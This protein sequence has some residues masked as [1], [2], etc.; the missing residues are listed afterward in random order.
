[1]P[2]P[3]GEVPD[4]GSDVERH[5]SEPARP[6]HA[7][8][9]GASGGQLARSEMDDRVERHDRPQLTVPGRQREQVAQAEFG[10]RML[11]AG[12]GDHAVGQI[13]AD[14]GRAV[15]GQPARDVARAAAEVGHR[16]TV[17]GL[18][19]EGAEQGP[20][21]WLVREFVAETVGVSAGHGVIAAAGHLVPPGYFHA[22]L[23]VTVRDADKDA[24]RGADKDAVRGA[25]KDAVRGAD[26]DA[27]RG[28]DK[29]AVRGADKD[30]GRKRL[31][32]AG[33]SPGSG[34]REGREGWAR[35]ATSLGFG[36]ATCIVALPHG[37]R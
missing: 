11:P 21:E 12:H 32:R 37:S 27:V 18:L 15:P 5:Q 16:R 14:H 17:P 29:D 19:D 36:G 3:L 10:H 33:A 9:F 20:V 1:M 34:G 26:K 8:H 13:D 31:Y 28:A 30:A 22:P 6:Q 2:P 35:L 4:L 24:V 7:V 25:D 23:R